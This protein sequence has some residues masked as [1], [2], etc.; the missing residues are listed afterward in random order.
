M[1]NRTLNVEAASASAAGRPI[2]VTVA[3]WV[4]D[5]KSIPNRVTTTRGIVRVTPE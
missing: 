3:T 2:E 4:D 1:P 5:G